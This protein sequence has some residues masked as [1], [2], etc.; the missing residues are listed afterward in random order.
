MST[1]DAYFSVVASCGL[2]VQQTPAMGESTL[3]PGFVYLVEAADVNAIYGI[4]AHP[5]ADVAGKRIALKVI[6]AIDDP[7]LLEIS[8]PDGQA[9]ED[10]GGYIATGLVTVGSQVL[11]AYREW[12]CDPDGNWLMVA[13]QLGSGDVTPLGQIVIHGVPVVV[14]GVPLV[15]TTPAPLALRRPTPTVATI[16]PRTALR[17]L[18]PAPLSGEVIELEDTFDDASLEMNALGEK[19]RVAETLQAAINAT[20]DAVEVALDELAEL[21]FPFTLRTTSVSST[22][23]ESIGVLRFDA[24]AL[25]AAFVLVAELEVSAAGQTVELQLYDLTAAAVVA[26]L[27]STSTVTSKQTASVTLPLAEHLYDVRLRRVGGTSA[28]LV[29]CRSVSLTR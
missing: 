12:M 8:A 13:L 1:L 28:Q 29:S 10:D 25:G 14:R 16:V 6:S 17:A 26:T 7:G 4:A 11:G 19:F 15:N 24:T 2:R 22:S 21:R 9:I 20:S 23:F 27:S 5:I 18:A 3:E